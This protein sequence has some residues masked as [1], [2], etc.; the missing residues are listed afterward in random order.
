MKLGR[1]KVGA[2]FTSILCL[3]WYA[4]WIMIADVFRGSHLSDKSY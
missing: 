3:E 1:V 4:E 2:L